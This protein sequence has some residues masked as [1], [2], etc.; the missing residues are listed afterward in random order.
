MGSQLKNQYIYKKKLGE[1]GFGSVYLVEKKSVNK[2]Y[3]IKVQYGSKSYETVRN[4]V[5]QLKKMSH[6]N[7]VSYYGS[8][9]E[10]NKSYIIME[11]ACGG[12]LREILER[13][14]RPFSEQVSLYFA[15]INEL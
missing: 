5:E 4:E 13:R 11:Y 15:Y 1:G 10:Q 8:W 3:V 12:N 7:V 2:D 6:P 9:T 14:E